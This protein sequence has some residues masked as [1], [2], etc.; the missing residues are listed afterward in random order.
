MMTSK[1]QHGFTCTRAPRGSG[2]RRE[3]IHSPRERT[4][5]ERIVE[6]NIRRTFTVRFPNLYCVWQRCRDIRGSYRNVLLLIVL[7]PE[8]NG[9]R[10]RRVA[11]RRTKTENRERGRPFERA[12]D[13]RG[14]YREGEYPAKE[15]KRER[16]RERARMRERWRKRGSERE[17]SGNTACTGAFDRPMNWIIASRVESR[18]S[19]KS[20][21]PIRPYMDVDAR[22]RPRMCV[23][24]FACAHKSTYA[25][26]KY[27]AGGGG[28][29]ERF[30]IA[31]GLWAWWK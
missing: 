7:H 20:Q 24:V 12:R 27:I 15:R 2:F 6:S 18:G 21:S 8:G 9:G 17:R 22:N 30:Y 26:Y 29:E 31:R 23:H 13:R 28:G 3:R 19:A 10:G 5:R 14:L 4:G 16:E 1:F 11:A 25:I